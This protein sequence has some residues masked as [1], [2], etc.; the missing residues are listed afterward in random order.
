[1]QRPLHRPLRPG[2][3]QTGRHRGPADQLTR[4]GM[5]LP[6]PGLSLRRDLPV[7]GRNAEAAA[8][9]EG[10]RQIPCTRREIVPRYLALASRSRVTVA[11]SAV[12]SQARITGSRLK[13]IVPL[14]IR[15]CSR[16]KVRPM[17]RP[18][19]ALVPAPA[20]RIEPRTNGKARSTAKTIATVRAIFDQK[21]KRYCRASSE[22]VWKYWMSCHRELNVSCS[23]SCTARPR[24]PAVTFDCSIFLPGA[25]AVT[26]STGGGRHCAEFRPQAGWAGAGSALR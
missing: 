17:P 15:R 11:S 1:G 10:G 19:R 4:A 13:T 18:S 2:S 6:D 14:S 21:A 5:G 3:G 16:K 23:G 26:R 20:E 9:E 25:L 8:G 24:K 12:G 22:L 7:D